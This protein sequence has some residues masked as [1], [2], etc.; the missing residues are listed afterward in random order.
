TTVG[1]VP[2]KTRSEREARTYAVTDF[3]REL[4]APGIATHI[5]FV[6]D[7][8]EDPVYVAVR[9]MVRRIADHAGSLTFALETGQESAPVL[10]EFLKDADRP[11]L[12]INFDPANMILYGTG[13]PIEALTLLAPRVLSAHAKDGIWPTGPGELGHETPLGEGA[14]DIPG[15]LAKLRE[16]GYRK[17]VFIERESSDA[18]QRLIDIASA[19]N[20]ILQAQS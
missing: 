12:G 11:N 16:T 3:A 14:V 2:Q 4:G 20:L 7:D 13:D 1:F 17:P 5:G 8:S 19:R 10:L 9:E 6:P 18:P 15:F